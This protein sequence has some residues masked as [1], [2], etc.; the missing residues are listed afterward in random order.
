M[1]N[2]NDWASFINDVSP[3]ECKKS[4]QKLWDMLLTH[5]EDM[6][7]PTTC[8]GYEDA[9]TGCQFIWD[10]GEHH[11]E[12]EITDDNELEWFYMNRKNEK[13]IAGRDGEKLGVS[14]EL[15][16]YIGRIV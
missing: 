14:E 8:G 11:L 4:M 1:N 3:S 2:K 10:G 15:G 9:G 13:D 5:R 7:I 16:G 12:I 6:P